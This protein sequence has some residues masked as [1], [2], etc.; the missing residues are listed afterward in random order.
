MDIFVHVLSSSTNIMC[1]M[2]TL[3]KIRKIVIENNFTQIEYKVYFFLLDYEYTQSMI[4][5]QLSM[6][7]VSVRKAIK[8]LL[9]RGFVRKTKT[10]GRNKFFTANIFIENNPT[11]TQSFIKFFKPQAD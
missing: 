1:E 7:L 11:E 3:E 10:E 4:A 6:P 9:E 2:N 8:G 5:Q